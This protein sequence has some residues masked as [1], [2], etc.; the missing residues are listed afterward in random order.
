MLA[1]VYALVAEGAPTAASRTAFPATERAQLALLT[2]PVGG[3]S[4]IAV[5][6]TYRGNKAVVAA[7]IAAAAAL[8]GITAVTAPGR[9]RGPLR[10]GLRGRPAIRPGPGRRGGRPC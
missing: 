9:H 7:A 8:I 5:A 10:R 4:A 2:A 1:A 6:A 3:I